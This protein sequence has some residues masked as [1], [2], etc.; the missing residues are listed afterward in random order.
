MIRPAAPSL[1][2]APAPD[3]FADWEA[4]LALI[5]NSFAYMD[6]RIAPPSSA[7]ALT[8]QALRERARREYLYLAGS[9]LIGCAF[10]AVQPDALYLGKLAIAPAEQ[11]RGLGRLFL[12]EAE[13]LARRLNLPRLRLETRIE[14]SGNHAAFGR[15]GFERTAAKSHPGFDRITSITM[16]KPLFPAPSG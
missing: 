3:D 10:F 13:T 9:P 7:L 14:L 16:E 2:P 8:P 12:V 5:L 4:L 6:G 15:M 1:R 11:G